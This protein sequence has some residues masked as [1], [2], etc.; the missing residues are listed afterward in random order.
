VRN[1]LRSHIYIITSPFEFHHI[2]G[3]QYKSLCKETVE[4]KEEDNIE[5]GDRDL[6]SI[7]SYSTVWF[8]LIVTSPILG[9][10]IDHSPISCSAHFKS[11][12]VTMSAA[13]LSQ[14][15]DY[16]HIQTIST[17]S[18]LERDHVDPLCTNGCDAKSS[19]EDHESGGDGKSALTFR[20]GLILINYLKVFCNLLTIHPS[21]YRTPFPVM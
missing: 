3:L 6:P 20:A 4:E 2:T 15:E 16:L 7:P 1:R 11:H 17:T 12:Q 18:R 19:F 14:P 5:G 13:S 21:A 10:I 9:L 8:R